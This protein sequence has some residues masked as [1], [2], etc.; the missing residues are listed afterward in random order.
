MWDY[1]TEEWKILPYAVLT[2]NMD[3]DTSIPNITESEYNE[4][5]EWL[6]KSVAG[7]VLKKMF[8]TL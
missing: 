8:Y 1:P 6:E 5:D 3:W 2:P 4:Y 7:L